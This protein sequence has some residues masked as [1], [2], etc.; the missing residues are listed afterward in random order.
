MLNRLTIRARLILLSGVLLGVLVGTNLYLVRILAN[1]SQGAARATELVDLIAVANDA[2]IA[3]GEVRYWTADLAVSLLTASERNAAAARDRMNRRLDKLA[4]Q[5]PE[6]V[7]NVRSEF[8]QF[9]KSAADAVD[10][11]TNDRRIVGNS[12]I[13]QAR[14]HSVVVDRLLAS[15]ITKLEDEAKVARDRVVSDAVEATRLSLLTVLVAVLAGGLLTFFVVRSIARPLGHL[16][17]AI[18]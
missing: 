9:E 13:A 17:E 12:L 2:R 15:L 8:P 7:A 11:Y 4:V 10:E 5:N 16:I 1:N 3:F 18:D 14:Q 6:L